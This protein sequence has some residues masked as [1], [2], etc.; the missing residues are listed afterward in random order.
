[1]YILIGVYCAAVDITTCTSV[2]IV[3]FDFMRHDIKTGNRTIPEAKPSNTEFQTFYTCFGSN[4]F[5]NISIDKCRQFDGVVCICSDQM[6]IALLPIVAYYGGLGLRR[7][8]SILLLVW[9]NGQFV[10]CCE[11]FQYI[12]F[13]STL[14]SDLLT[15]FSIFQYF[16]SF[17][18]HLEILTNLFKPIFTSMVFF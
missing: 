10:I 15:F 12:F 18:I 6:D 1:M 11:I 5:L 9:I 17:R 13:G 3:C 2:E 8:L 14:F 4:W 7:M 16:I